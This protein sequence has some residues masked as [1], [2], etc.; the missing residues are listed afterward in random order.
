VTTA[1][2]NS[3]STLRYLWVGDINIV[4]NQ[5]STVRNVFSETQMNYDPRRELGTQQKG[6]TF[7]LDVKEY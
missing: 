7:K 3:K 1:M 6:N 5:D 2:T 4:P